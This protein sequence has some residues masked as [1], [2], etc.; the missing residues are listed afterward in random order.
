MVLQ[1]RGLSYTSQR[2]CSSVASAV[3]NPAMSVD[4]RIRPSGHLL[5]TEPSNVEWMQKFPLAL[6][7]V[8]IGWYNMFER[9]AEH[10]IGVTKSFCQSFDGSRVQVRGLNFTVTE[11]SISHAIDVLPEG[12]R[13]CKRKTINEDY[14]QYLFPAHKNPYWSQGIQRSFLFKEWKNVF[15][16]I[17]R[18]VTCEGRFGTVYHYHMHFLQ[19]VTGANKLNLPLFLLESLEKMSVRVQNHPISFGSNMF[20]HGLVNLLITQEL[21]K[22]ER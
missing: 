6:K 19:H 18:Y 20:H 10:H 11:E 5:R 14:S 7:R 2:S 9:I 3:Y 8:K 12:E 1:E 22:L 4:R 17:Q 13:W 21:G 16:I 15:Q